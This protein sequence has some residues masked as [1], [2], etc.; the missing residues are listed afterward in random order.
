MVNKSKWL[1]NYY[2]LDP[3][4]QLIIAEAIVSEL[5]DNEE[6]LDAEDKYDNEK[7]KIVRNLFNSI[8]ENVKEA[9]DFKKFS[10]IIGKYEALS[11]NHKKEVMNEISE[12]I[13]DHISKQEQE[14]K[15]Q[16]CWK[17]GHIFGKW[18]HNKWTEYSDTYIDHEFIHDYP[19]EKENWKRVCERCGFIEKV[20]KEP[21]ELIDAR[22]EKDRKERIKKLETELKRL[23]NE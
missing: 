8:V 11:D 1:Y 18:K 23:K 6:L 9:K 7:S 15:E 5:K 21:Q 22:K 3:D 10:D 16:T 20:E 14:L 4:N 2:S 19:D 17:E 12:I 13:S